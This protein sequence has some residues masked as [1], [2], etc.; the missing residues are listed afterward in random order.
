MPL[1]QWLDAKVR[2]QVFY[3]DIITIVLQH[4]AELTD[5]SIFAALSSRFETEFHQDM[6]ALNVSG[7]T[8]VTVN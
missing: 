7:V 4:G 8:I 5:H 3:D 6:A 1:S 2:R